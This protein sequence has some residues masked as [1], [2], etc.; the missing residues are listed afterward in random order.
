MSCDKCFKE[1]AHYHIIMEDG[2]VATVWYISSSG[3][4][5]RELEKDEWFVEDEKKPSSD[6]GWIKPK[7]YK[8]KSMH[9]LEME[10]EE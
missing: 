7:V 1:E 9:E 6:K 8:G 2:K 3:Y 10:G 4:W 5:D